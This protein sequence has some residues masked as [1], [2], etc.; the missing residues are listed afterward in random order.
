MS[1]KLLATDETLLKVN[2]NL[3][4]LA[5]FVGA[6]AASDMAAAIAD[7]HK[8]HEIIQAGLAPDILSIGDQIIVPH[9]D[10]TNIV[11]DVIGFDH[12][13]DA[14]GLYQHSVTVQT[15]F[16]ID[17]VVFDAVENEVATE[18]SF[19]ADY[20]YYVA[21]T[22]NESGFRLLVA[23]TDYTI[24]GAIPSGTTYYHSAIED[25]TGYICK[26]GYNSWEH[27]AIRQW[28]NSEKAKGEWWAAQHLGDVAPAYASTKDGFLKGLDA[29]FK[30]II[31]TT[32]K[33]TARNTKTDGGGSVELLEKIFLLSTTEVS[34][35][36]NN[37]IA[38][39]KAYEYY[40]RL[41]GAVTTAANTGRIKTLENGT[42]HWWG[43]RDPNT[44]YS[45]YVRICGYDGT[46]YNYSTNA[47]TGGRGLSPACILV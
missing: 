10:Y 33:V 18:A 24:G 40:S 32:K 20:H 30:S 4:R 12:D 11:F 26:Y 39:G 5:G 27:S 2:A 21:D 46:V 43:L 9:S 34:G 1:A 31:G 29:D 8:L 14:T 13:E 25:P 23:G 44:G 36:N 38:E 3:E 35:G 28:L 15:H 37:S 17:K 7:P 22:T 42:I 6:M 45:Y 19:S 47:Y 41:V 16:I